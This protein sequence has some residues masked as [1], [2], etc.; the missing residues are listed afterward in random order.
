MAKKANPQ[1]AGPDEF[2]GQGGSYLV[3]ADGRR[4]LA[5]RTKPEEP[6][7][8]PTPASPAAAAPAVTETQP[9]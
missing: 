7:L 2:H 5:E 6:E 1:D 3:G 4:T 8:A 9:E